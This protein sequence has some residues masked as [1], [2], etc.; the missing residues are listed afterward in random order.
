MKC[1]HSMLY[2]YLMVSVTVFGVVLSATT[3][4]WPLVTPR[5]E[6]GGEGR[7]EGRREG[8]R[9]GEKREGGRE[10]RREERGGRKEGGKVHTCAYTE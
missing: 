4:S 5:S 10:G 7:R 2:S 8:G 9:E 3:T 1:S 6:R